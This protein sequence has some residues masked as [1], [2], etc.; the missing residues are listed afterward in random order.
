MRANKGIRIR[1][2]EVNVLLFEKDIIL[3]QGNS[4]KPMN[5]LLQSIM[6]H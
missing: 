5:Y 6:K 2:E 3:Y 4:R 1:E